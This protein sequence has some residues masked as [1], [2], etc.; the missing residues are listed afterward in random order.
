VLDFAALLARASEGEMHVGHAWDVLGEDYLRRAL[1]AETLE[2]ELLER[3]RAARER[4]ER[5]KGAAGDASIFGPTHVRKGDPAEVIPRLAD[6]IGADLVVLG[7]TSRTG[8]RAVFI[9]STVETIIGRLDCSV[10]LVKPPGFS[11][12]VIV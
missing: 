10:L 2:A 11:T 12:P 1:G 8:R 9:G 4:V 3:D 5:A 7:N 6:E